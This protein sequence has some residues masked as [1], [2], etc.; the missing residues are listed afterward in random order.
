MCILGLLLQ[1]S[2]DIPFLAV[3]NRDEFF[4]RPVEH[5][6]QIHSDII[7]GRDVSAG[8]TWLGYNTRTHVYAALTNVRDRVTGPPSPT[9]RGQLVLGLLRGDGVSLSE[10]R[11]ACDNATSSAIAA[12][13]VGPGR[14]H[15][16]VGS[17]SLGAAY[18]GFNLVVADL[19]T[20]QPEVFFLTNRPVHHGPLVSGTSTESASPSAGPNE[21]G[22]LPGPGS[23]PVSIPTDAAH[24]ERLGHGVHVLSNSTI[25]DAAWAKVRWVRERLSETAPAI[26]SLAEMRMHFGQPRLPPGKGHASDMGVPGTARSSLKDATGSS[27]RDIGPNDPLTPAVY[28]TVAQATAHRALT[29]QHKGSIHE[30]DQI[31]E[32][33]AEAALVQEALSHVVGIM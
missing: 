17:V 29:R 10:I 16:G 23:V 20:S 22:P 5:P 13:H 19:S 12:G 27:I 14:L 2:R 9:S 28:P 8:G 1:V 15:H 18:A 25:N 4:H 32:E 6:T 3:H 30:G 33:R 24:A 26:P 11:Q 21:A 7:F 31:L